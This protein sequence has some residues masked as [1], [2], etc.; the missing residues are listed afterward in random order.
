MSEE[1]PPTQD[2]LEYCVKDVM[3][4]LDLP[5]IPEMGNTKILVIGGLAIK[6]LTRLP[7]DKGK[8]QTDAVCS[9]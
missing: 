9:S 3:R 8:C 6:L 7:Y 5:S 4:H 1:V 2:E